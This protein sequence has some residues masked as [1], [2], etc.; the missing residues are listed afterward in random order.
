MSN[1]SS[2][3]NSFAK[4]WLSDNFFYNVS[5]CMFVYLVNVEYVKLLGCFYTYI[6]SNCEDVSHY[7]FKIFVSFSLASPSG[8]PIMYILILLMLHKFL[9]LFTFLH[10]FFSF[11]PQMTYFQICWF[12]IMFESSFGSKIFQFSYYIFSIF[13]FFTYGYGVS[14]FYI[15]ILFIVLFPLVI[16]PCFPLAF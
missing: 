9:R 11:F 13:L 16:C 7:F 10:S 4:I 12:L 6:L 14:F 15:L 3:L 8:T 1:Y 5:Q 2:F